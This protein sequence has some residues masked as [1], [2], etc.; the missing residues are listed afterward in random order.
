MV[1]RLSSID[2]STR[3]ITFYDKEVEEE[4]NKYG[5][6]GICLFQGGP[7]TQANLINHF[8]QISKTPILICIDAE[9]GLGMRMDSV[10]SLP[11]QMMLGA[12]QDSFLIYQYGKVVGDQCRRMGV[13]V[14]FAPVVDINN[15]PDNPVINDRSFG[16]DKYRVAQYGIEYMKGMQEAGVMACAKHFPGHG[17][18]SVDSHVDLPVINKSRKQLDSLELYPFKAMI[19]AGLPGIMVAHLYI[20]AIDKTSHLASSLSYKNVTKLLKKQLKF[21]GLSFTDALEMK[22]VTKYFPEGDASVQSLIAGNDIVCL[23]GD[24]G[25]SLQKIREAIENRKIKWK[26]INARVKK[27][28][29]AKYEYGLANWQPVSTVHLVEDLNKD[30]PDLSR[31]VVQHALTVLRNEEQG[32]FPL[33]VS[34]KKIAFIG[35]GLTADNEF[36]RRMVKD[37]QAHDYYFDN[38]LESARALALLALL[39]D[40]YDELIIGVHNYNRFP[41]NDF[42][43]SKT[44]LWLI[45]Q[46]QKQ[47]MR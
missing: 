45:Q 34:H 44:S 33:P 31:G 35:I 20:P 26:E 17:D 11:R 5:I 29:R 47:I 10:M 43:I 30:L 42:G 19:R 38:S 4:V 6:G 7:V 28:L 24:V 25:L 27:L 3:K 18:V 41:A 22:G 13:Q 21:E 32:V 12:V 23:P 9:N 36:A 14:N 37:Y 1:V 40:R 2:L 46:L 39:K 8:Q 15:N 16:E